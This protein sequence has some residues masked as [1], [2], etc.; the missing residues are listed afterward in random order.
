MSS[1]RQWIREASAPMHERVDAAYSR[2]EL[3]DRHDYGRFLRAHGAALFSLEATLEQGGISRLLS[4]WPERRRSA[5]LREDLQTLKI[6]LPTP[7]SLEPGTGEG[8]S[9]GVAY[10][11]EGS[12]IGGRVLSQRVREGGSIG[13]LRYLGHGEGTPLWP[14]FL[15]QFEHRAKT[16]DRDQLLAGVQLAFGQFLCAA[17]HE[18]QT[19]TS[20]Q[21]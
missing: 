19:A 14:R 8:W 9:W 7:L 11:L 1:L 5:A 20:V 15:V 6:A 18:L 2:F 17:E 13:P 3:S 16:V 21:P 12:R 4:D 10:V